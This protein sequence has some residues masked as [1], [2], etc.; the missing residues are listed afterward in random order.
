[1][2]NNFL[3]QLPLEELKLIS[4]CP[5]CNE[6]HKLVEAKILEEKD[7]NYLIYLKCKKCQ[8]SIITLAT[9]NGMGINS[10]GLVVDL[11]V[12]DVLKFKDFPVINSDDVILTYQFLE[13]KQIVNKN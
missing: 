9:H 13:E 5:I 12:E 2:S 3:S 11:T 4:F 6:H 7:N 1:M 10:V 8:S